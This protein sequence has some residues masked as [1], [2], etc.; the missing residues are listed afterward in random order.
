MPQ[1]KFQDFIYTIIMVIVMVYAMVC[2]NI[3][4]NIGGLTNE[5]FVMALAELPIMGVIAF[6]LEFF[7]IGKLAQKLA[8]RL[9]NP[10]E[11]K[12]IFV[13]L[14]I[15]SMIVCLMCPIMSFFG[16]VLFNFTGWQNIF[17]N[18][19]RIAVMNFPMALCWQIFYAGPFVRF[20][21]KRIF[22][23]QLVKSASR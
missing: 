9:V 8:F 19:I 14:A 23:K 17:A 2:Y 12:Q 6:V 11:D 4:V 10:K 18:W 1:T 22:K 3:A 21:F 7:I 16:S 20:I 5:V 15:S 13:I